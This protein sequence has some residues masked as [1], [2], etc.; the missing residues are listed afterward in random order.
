VHDSRWEYS[1]F[2]HNAEFIRFDEAQR[3]DEFHNICEVLKDK[4]NFYPWPVGRLIYYRRGTGGYYLY[5]QLKEDF[6]VPR[7]RKKH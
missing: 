2:E 5:R 3:I 7:E 4:P 6:R 1:R